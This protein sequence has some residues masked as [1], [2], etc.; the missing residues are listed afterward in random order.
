MNNGKAKF[1]KLSYTYKLNFLL[2]SIHETE[3]IF[4]KEKKMA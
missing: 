4:S 3:I 2:R 1:F